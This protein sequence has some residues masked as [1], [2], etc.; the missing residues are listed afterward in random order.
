MSKKKP[1]TWATLV[2]NGDNLN[3]DQV[4]LRLGI[5]ADYTNDQNSKN[6]EEK[7]TAPHWQLNSSLPPTAIYSDHL[8]DILKK[9]APKRKELKEISKNCEAVVYT[10]VEFADWDI[11]GISLEPRL[12]L[13]LGDLGIK[14]EFLPWLEVE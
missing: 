14:L 4:S 13:L 3:P 8:W 1:R 9:I 10:S 11:D 5:T 6:F 2:L 7:P 12:L